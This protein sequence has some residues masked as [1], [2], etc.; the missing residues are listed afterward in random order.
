ME[1]VKLHRVIIARPGTPRELVGCA[2]R[3]GEEAFLREVASAIMKGMSLETVPSHDLRGTDYIYRCDIMTNK[4]RL[5]LNE[6]LIK[7]ESKVYSQ[8][9]EIDVCKLDKKALKDQ[10]KLIRDMPWYTKIW[11]VI[12]G[13]L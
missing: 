8:R 12:R 11:E 3:D 6:K 5:G 1:A 9:F 2:I 13:R 4:E 7:L 10:I